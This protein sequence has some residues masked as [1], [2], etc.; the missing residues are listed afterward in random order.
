MA[1]RRRGIRLS[2]RTKVQ[3]SKNNVQKSF[4]TEGIIK[5]L[6]RRGFA[7]MSEDPLSRGMSYLFK[8]DLM[9]IPLQLTG[10]V[11]HLHELETYSVYGVRM[12]SMP[13]FDRIRF[14]QFLMARDFGM[15]LRYLAYSLGLGLA[16]GVLVSVLFGWPTAGALSTFFL[17]AI[18]HFMFPPF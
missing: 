9:G 8:I 12:D 7:F 6:S 14:N 17:V 16:A 3:I 4:L 11:A 10:R 15:K 1:E 18:V 2:Y 5:N 13:L